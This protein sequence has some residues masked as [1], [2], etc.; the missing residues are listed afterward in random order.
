MRESVG[1]EMVKGTRGKGETRP[2]RHEGDMLEISWREPEHVTEEGGVAITVPLAHLMAAE[3]D[4][5]PFDTGIPSPTTACR[6]Q[7]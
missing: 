4:H 6:I 3:R 2:A 7:H 5:H 1:D